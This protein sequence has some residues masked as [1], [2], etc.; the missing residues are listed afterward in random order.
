MRFV[1]ILLIAIGVVSGTCR[2]YASEDYPP[3]RWVPA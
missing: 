3:A 1:Y 2:M